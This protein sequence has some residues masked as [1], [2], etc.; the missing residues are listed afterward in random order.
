MQQFFLVSLYISLGCLVMVDFVFLTNTLT[1]SLLTIVCYICAQFFLVS[2]YI[3]L[4]CMKKLTCFSFLFR[5]FDLKSGSHC[6]SYK[7]ANH[8]VKN[9]IC[10]PTIIH[11]PHISSPQCTNFISPLI[12]M[13]RYNWVSYLFSPWYCMFDKRR[14]HW[15]EV[16]AIASWQMCFLCLLLFLFLL[17]KHYFFI[18][19]TFFS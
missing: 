9:N 4:F 19:N 7:A 11:V 2:L 6:H 15:K 1:V 12:L 17:P 18:D 16:W 13:R 5:H 3:S 10:R 8:H 14:S